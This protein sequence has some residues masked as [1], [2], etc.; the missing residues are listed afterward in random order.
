MTRNEHLQLMAEQKELKLM[1]S[2]IPAGDVLDRMGLEGRLKEIEGLIGTESKLGPEP[3]RARVTFRG[4][5]VV[6]SHGIFAEFGAAAMGSFADLVAAMAASHATGPLKAMGPIPNRDEH[7]LLITN[8]VPG[9]FGFEVEEFQDELALAGDASAMA[10]A[11]E[12]TQAILEGARN[13]NDDELADVLSETDSRTLNAVR[14]FLKVMV[15]A[16][17]SCGLEYRERMVRFTDPGDV[18]RSMQRLGEQNVK[19]STADFTGQFLGVLPQHRTFEFEMEGEQRVIMGKVGPS[20]VDAGMLND[21]VK[22]RV[23]IKVVETRVGS[24]RPRYVLSEPPER[25]P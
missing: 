12:K 10:V 13:S 7:Q 21:V 8:T 19:E 17:A 15:D 18:Q 22:Q 23:T 5:P 1:L 4:G 16:E 25:V 3:A 11:L 20:I 14:N 2:H 24:G 6:G 9:S